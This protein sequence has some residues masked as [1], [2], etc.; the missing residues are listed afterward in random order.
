MLFHFLP[1]TALRVLCRILCPSPRAADRY[2]HS[3]ARCGPWLILPEPLLPQYVFTGLQKHSALTYLSDR[4][5][6]QPPQ[7]WLLQPPVPSL[8]WPGK[9]LFGGHTQI[10]LTDFMRVLPSFMHHSKRSLALRER[11]G[12]LLETRGQYN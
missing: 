9:V 6:Q 5:S 4:N 10:L 8:I 7:R 2:Q 1:R 3:S 12:K 11:E